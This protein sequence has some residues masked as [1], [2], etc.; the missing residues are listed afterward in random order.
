M[1]ALVDEADRRAVV[2]EAL[3]RCEGQKH[4]STRRNL[5]RAMMLIGELDKSV[6]EEIMRQKSV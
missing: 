2:K 3:S 1:L 5:R 6:V 4:A